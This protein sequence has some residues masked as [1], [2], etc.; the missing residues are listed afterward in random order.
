MF[1]EWVIGTS[2]QSYIP[3]PKPMAKRKDVIR[4]EVTTDDES[5]ADTLKI[6]YPRLINFDNKSQDSIKKVRFEEKP[7]S[8]LKQTKSGSDADTSASEATT[9]SE[10][11]TDSEA[12]CGDAKAKK[13]KSNKKDE[14]EPHPT[15]K[16]T[17]CV[18]GR[19][20]QKQDKKAEE[21]KKRREGSDA[22][23]SDA[24]EKKESKKNKKQDKGGK[25]ESKKEEKA[26]S[27]A[28]EG[29]TTDGGTSDDDKAGRKDNGKK[30]SKKDE[31]RRDGDKSTENKGGKEKTAQPAAPE[32]QKAY[33]EAYPFYHPR[34]PNLIGPIRAQVIQTEPVVETSEDPPP[35]AFYDA[36]H[37]IMR[38][39]HGPVYGNHF[40]RSLYPKRDQAN[41]PLPVGMPHPAQ[42]PYLFGF[43]NLP[44]PA[45]QDNARIWAQHGFPP[46][47]QHPPPAPPEHHQHQHQHQQH[48]QPSNGNGS[49]GAFS[50]GAVGPDD[51]VAGKSNVTPAAA[52]VSQA[53][54]ENARLVTYKQ[55]PY[56]S[57]T[58]NKSVFSDMGSNRSVGNGSLRNGAGNSPNRNSSANGQN[59]Q[60]NSWDQQ[61]TTQEPAPVW[62]TSAPN[63]NTWNGSNNNNG[64]DQDPAW[65]APADSNNNGNA[66]GDGAASNDNQATWGT[67]NDNNDNNQSTWGNQGENNNE[68]NNVS[69]GNGNND[70]SAS[71]NNQPVPE[72]QQPQQPQDQWNDN[73]VDNVGPMPGSW[74]D[75]QPSGGDW[76]D[77]TMA[78]TTNGKIDMW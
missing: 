19:Q 60:S 65:N 11:A 14:S 58:R 68:T 26:D 74:N 71:W 45:G 13:K 1:A 16:C 75:E 35:N 6:T 49:K 9:D 36:E 25:K 5:E 44:G 52:Q 53:H 39:Y 76:K 22:K 70:N 73:P 41:R 69:W 27:S 72:Q 48:R 43:K 21:K 29:D 20:K 50:R 47:Q 67:N 28:T 55:N 23:S 17:K 12:D 4:V 32:Q 10:A 61:N 30:E 46:C 42:N 40:S 33:P 8:A 31:K 37:N 57:P 38:V 64:G 59:N 63:N 18:K 34:L 54:L 15:C 77:S 56:Y 78:A 62:D 3:K 66:W 7:K 51:D 24:S 2:L